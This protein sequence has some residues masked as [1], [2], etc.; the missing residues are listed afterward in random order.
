MQEIPHPIPEEAKKLEEELRKKRELLESEARRRATFGNTVSDRSMERYNELLGISIEE[1][2]GKTVL[3]LGSG[4]TER[5]AKEMVTKGVNV[6][7][8]NPD[9]TSKFSRD[10]IKPERL[11]EL[12]R[13]WGFAKTKRESVAAIGQ[14]LPFHDEVFDAVTS[15]YAISLYLPEEHDEWRAAFNELLRV[16]KPGG[17]AYVAPF[18]PSIQEIFF[19]A[20]NEE[21]GKGQFRFE[22]KGDRLII[23]K[24]VLEKESQDPSEKIAA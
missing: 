7:S 17:R 21:I 22:I 19:D 14:N 9:L 1:L 10:L 12:K 4:L 11:E 8:V 15:L 16:L 20:M 6:V 13:R 3:D 2:K 18:F 23:E 24:P 5:F